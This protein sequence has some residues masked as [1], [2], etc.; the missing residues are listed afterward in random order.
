MSDS[1]MTLVKKFVVTKGLWKAHESG[2]SVV[3]KPID[4]EVRNHEIEIEL[5]RWAEEAYRIYHTPGT[6]ARKWRTLKAAK[7]FTYSDWS[8]QVAPTDTNSPDS[9]Y[10]ITLSKLKK[11]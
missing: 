7:H 2:M 5:T 6:Y 11:E 8:V 3:D 10:R 9:A 4:F 1:A